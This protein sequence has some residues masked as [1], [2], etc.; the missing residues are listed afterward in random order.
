MKPAVVV[1]TNVP[2]VSNRRSDQASPAC[3]IA[4]IERLKRIIEMEAERLALDAGWLIISEYQHNLK[5]EG[6]PGFGDA[7]LKWV[8]TN[9]ANLERCERVVITPLDGNPT[10]FQEF[11]RDP[12]LAHFDPS[13]RKFIAVALA[14]EGRRPV[15]QAVDTKWWQANDALIR[16]GV[17]VEFV[18]EDDIRRLCRSL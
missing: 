13:D 4:C 14:G 12:G 10:D 5:S 2:V 7:F 18:C 8:L 16:N 1:D 15:V 3:V 11:P 17:V 9:W 6:Q